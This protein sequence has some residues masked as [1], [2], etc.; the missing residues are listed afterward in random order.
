MKVSVEQF[1][2]MFENAMSTSS[3]YSYDI[4]ETSCIEITCCPATKMTRSTSSAR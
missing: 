1:Y 3:K 4:S 2:D